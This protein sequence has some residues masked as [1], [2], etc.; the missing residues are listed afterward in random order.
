VS[1]TLKGKLRLAS[2]SLLVLVAS[3]ALVGVLAL[4]EVTSGTGRMLDGFTRLDKVQELRLALGRVLIA[5]NDY[6]IFGNP[7]DAERFDRDIGTVKRRLRAVA[8]LV[9]DQRLHAANRVVDMLESHGRAVFRLDN[10]IGNR[11]GQG[12]MKR[13]DDMVQAATLDLD[14]LLGETRSDAIRA[15]HSANSLER[16]VRVIVASIGLA[17]FAIAFLGVFVFARRVAV[18]LGELHH[19]V[20]QLSSGDMTT[21]VRVAAHDEIGEIGESFNKMVVDLDEARAKL[22]DAERLA[23]IGQMAVTVKHEMNN[24]IH[25]IMAATQLVS[26]SPRESMPESVAEALEMITEGCE[27]LR[28]VVE[29]VT[30]VTEAKV[31]RYVGD[32]Q[33]IDIGPAEPGAK[34]DT[35]SGSEQG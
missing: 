26:D 23:A 6:L 19:A 8:D 31:T 24:P 11:L 27:R 18:R 34:V 28:E 9:D 5:P 22:V 3:L 33:M 1:A 20:S 12:L 17:A 4:D 35:G 30:N 21:R 16:D 14:A 32:E 2:A 7:E 10:P 13:L 25:G 29:R 15:A